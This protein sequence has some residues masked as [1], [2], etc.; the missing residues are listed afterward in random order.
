MQYQWLDKTEYPFQNQFTEIDGHKIH[1][2]DEGKGETILFVH[3][4]PSWSFDFRNV[5]KDLS[6]N[7]RCI[8]LDHLGFG[9]SDK[10]ANVTYNIDL[11]CRNLE[12]FVEKM[13]LDNLILVLHDFGGPI[14]FHFAQKYPHKVKGLVIM[15]SWMWSSENEPEYKRLKRILKSPLMPLLYKYFNFSA[16][17][18]LP[19]SFGKLKLTSDIHTQYIKPFPTVNS[20]LGTV[21][22][23]HSLLNDQPWFETLW[24]GRNLISAKPLLLIWGLRDP[25]LN[26]NYLT[27]FKQGFPHARVV[28]FADAGHFPQEECP[29]QVAF[30]MRAFV[31]DI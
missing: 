25:Y 11:H 12:A 19:K 28:T 29:N 10:P 14:G 22:F 1:Y 13:E 16:K 17:Y 9:L 30:A 5:I 20:R 8:A 6:R 7:Y 26:E 31:N 21:G 2:I 23:A 3:G 24:E 18:L 27:K 15:N 4:T